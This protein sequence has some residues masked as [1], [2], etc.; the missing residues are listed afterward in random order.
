M[1]AIYRINFHTTKHG[2]S[3]TPIYAVWSSMMQRCLDINFAQYSDY[4]D[5]GITVC[6]KWKSFNEFYKDMGNQPEGMT[7]ERIDN[8]KGYYKDNCKW[9]TRKE[10][11]NNRRTNRLITYRGKT[12]SL[13]LWVDEL[14]LN[15]Y[16]VKKRLNLNWTPEEAFNK[17]KVPPSFK[18]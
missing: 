18:F 12:Q 13:A 15:Y 6:D 5:R 8:T 11:A 14:G 4:G 10:Q 17:E 1:K 9:A 16:R 2:M 3:N 7:L